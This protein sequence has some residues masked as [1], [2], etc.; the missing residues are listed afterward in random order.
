MEKCEICQLSELC[1]DVDPSGY[2][3][4]RQSCDSCA[5]IIWLLDKFIVGGKSIKLRDPEL[6]ENYFYPDLCLKIQYK[7][8]TYIQSS[9]GSI[10]YPSDRLKI[11]LP[12][13]RIFNK[14]DF[15]LNNST[16][17]VKLIYYISSL[18]K[19]C[20]TTAFITEAKLVKYKPTESELREVLNS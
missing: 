8:C 12:L 19:H 14:S 1:H 15:D 9:D 18:A 6:D 5:K 2:T 13:L 3:V 17:S 4:F 10:G 7:Y 20:R 11:Q 16:K